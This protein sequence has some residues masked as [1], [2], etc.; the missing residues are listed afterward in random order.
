MSRTSKRVSSPTPAWRAFSVA[1][2]TRFGIEI[3]AQPARAA[4]RR[5]DDDAPVARA[6][7]DHVVA[8]LHLGHA[9]HALDD[10]HRRLHVR[11]GAVVP[12]P[13][14]RLRD[15]RQRGDQEHA[16]YQDLQYSYREAKSNRGVSGVRRAHPCRCAAQRQLHEASCGNCD[17]AYSSG[18]RMTRARCRVLVVDDERD[19]VLT[20][21]TFLRDEG[22]EV[23][24]LLSRAR[25]HA[26]AVKE[27]DPDVVLLDIALP[28]GSG[29]AVAEDIRRRDGSR[30]PDAHRPDGHLQPRPPHDRLSR[31]VGCDH[32]LTKPFAIPD[33]LKLIAPLTCRTRTTRKMRGHAPVAQWIEQPPPKG[34][35]ARS[36]RVR[37][38]SRSSSPAG[39][40]ASLSRRKTRLGRYR[41]SPAF[42]RPDKRA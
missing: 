11:H 19:T 34:Q 21:M 23:R 42:A 30:A 4:L 25:S 18:K 33:Q 20:L 6:E 22:H 8:L 12:G 39:R 38:A 41:G 32:F 17:T 15:R 1:C 27:F 3:D 29:Y 2:F 37:G 36:I 9:H 35:V 7:V 14:L 28:D 13:G 5:L 16:R 26:A 40:P 31:I 24:G 10:L